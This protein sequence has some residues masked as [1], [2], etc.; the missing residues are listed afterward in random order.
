[1]D[2]KKRPFVEGGHCQTSPSGVKCIMGT[3]GGKPTP[4]TLVKN[5]KDKKKK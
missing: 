4:F 1:M 5:N 3:P 2:T